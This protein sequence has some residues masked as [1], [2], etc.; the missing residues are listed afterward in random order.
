MN[1]KLKYC[2]C[3]LAAVIVA[4]IIIIIGDHQYHG[5]GATVTVND[6]SF[7]LSEDVECCFRY[8]EN[9]KEKVSSK[10]IKDGIKFKSHSD[11]KAAYE[12]TFCLEGNG[13][14]VYPRISFFHQFGDHDRY[15]LLIELTPNGDGTYKAV[16]KENGRIYY[17]CKDVEKD[18][19]AFQIGP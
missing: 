14:K 16:V 11:E 5:I 4:T 7:K 3:V 19:I 15:N 18:G 1:K 2:I 12:Y 17:M 8:D 9:Q 13:I 6:N 10:R